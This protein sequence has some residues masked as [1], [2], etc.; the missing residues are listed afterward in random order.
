MIN[1]TGIQENFN[2]LITEVIGQANTT[3]TYLNT[4]E[5]HLFNMVVSRDDYIDNLKSTI[6]NDCFSAMNCSGETNQTAINLIRSTHIITVNLERIADFSVNITRQVEFLFDRSLWLSFDFMKMCDIISAGLNQ[7]APATLNKNLGDA[8][9]ICKSEFDLDRLYKEHFDRIM[10]ELRRGENIETFI[11]ILFI[12]RYL[13]RIGDSLLNIGEAILF[14]IM[15]E[16]IKIR[17]FEAL[18]QT[19]TKSQL[20][21]PIDKL[22]FHSFWG[23]RSGCNITKVCPARLTGI[24]EGQESIFKTGNL[25]KIK[26]EKESIEKWGG[27]IPGLAPRI[28]SFHEDDEDNASLLIEFMSGQ[29]MDE[30]ILTAD[31]D[32]FENAI[33]HLEQILL[34]I[35]QKTKKPGASEVNY[36]KQLLA[37]LDAISRVHPEHIRN[38]KQLGSL[39]IES[40]T[41][42]VKK[43]HFV[44]RLLPAPF[45]VFIHGDFNMNN[46]LFDY[47]TKHVH[48]IDLYRSRHTGLL[49]DISVI[50]I[51]NFRMPVFDPPIRQR[52]HYVIGS[53]L[54][55]AREFCEKEGDTTFDARLTLAMARSFLTSTRFELNAAFAK[56]MSLRANFL[57]KKII[58][59]HEG[60]RPWREFRL[61]E[62]ILY[63]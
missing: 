36:M 17:Q 25:A 54:S 13:E 27:I 32:V 37:R 3:F 45:S 11:T 12:F 30:I 44:E 40:T 47:E 1:F 49:Q 28:F 29:T 63:Y 24:K 18:Q 2:F 42:L 21:L 57:M 20:N 51:S 19:L 55:F 61:P 41:E 4:F 15:G 60:K 31:R 23:T 58:C 8:L 39:T 46:I 7:V 10:V 16:K 34:Q 33:F 50:L 59:F 5:Q 53:I 56:E 62:A 38:H 9:R 14:A 22:H 26:K 35:W 52:I 6:E 43:C 48:F